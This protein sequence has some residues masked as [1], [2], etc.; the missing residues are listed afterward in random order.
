MKIYKA[1]YED[2]EFELLDS[3]SDSDAKFQAWEKED[4]HQMQTTILR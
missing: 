1:N 3:D 2:G 4:E